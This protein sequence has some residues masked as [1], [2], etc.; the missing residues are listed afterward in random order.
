M[1]KKTKTQIITEMTDEIDRLEQHVKNRDE[2]IAAKDEVI[3][4][5]SKTLKNMTDENK[6]LEQL[7]KIAKARISYW[8]DT[9][10]HLREQSIRFFANNEL[11]LELDHNTELIDE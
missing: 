10:F 11:G 8:K 4:T 7:C 5:L 2:I 9:Y 3:G 6:E 1:T